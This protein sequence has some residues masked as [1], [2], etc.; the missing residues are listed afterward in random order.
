MTEVQGLQRTRYSKLCPNDCG[1]RCDRQSVMCRPCRRRLPKQQPAAPCAECGRAMRRVP[2]RT[3]CQSCVTRENWRRGCF[4]N[5]GTRR[6][7]RWMS[8]EDQLIGHMAGRFT[9]A[10]ITAEFARIGWNRTVMAIQQRASKIG[11]YLII[12]AWSQ[13]RVRMLFGAHQA[14]TRHAWFD[15]G[16]LPAIRLPVGT[17]CRQGEWRVAEADIER[18]IRE[19][20]W[21]YDAARMQPASHPLVRLA[22]DIQRRDPWVE[23][24]EAI[25]YLGI[26]LATF[27]RWVAAGVIPAKRRR[28]TASGGAFGLGRLVV[29]A[30]DLP[31]A[32]EAILERRRAARAQLAA[33][34]RAINDKRRLERAA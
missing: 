11:V 31:A 24:S 28:I 18:F 15:A 34:I 25:S 27:S 2:A 20:P 10:Q 30:A 4:A 6:G 5:I 26:S 8:E 13:R 17:G 9:T 3:R 21:E 16:I 29:R 32:R 1:R 23:S 19:C 7:D 14:T 33:N 22:H 12:D